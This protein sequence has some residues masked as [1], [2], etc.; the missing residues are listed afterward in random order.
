MKSLFSLSDSQ[1]IRGLLVA[2][3][4]LPAWTAPAAQVKLDSLLVG[5]LSYTN[6]TVL[7][8]TTTHIFFTY[9][10]GS[11][12][13]KL[14]DLEPNLQARFHY[15]PTAAAEAE[16]Q[17]AADEAHYRESIAANIAANIAAQARQAALAAR[18]TAATSAESLADPVS[19][20]SLI[21]KPAPSIE[22]GKWLGE[23]P[24]L[25]GKLVLVVF[26]A[27]WSIPCRKYIPVLDG[28]QKKF[29]GKLAVVGVTSESEAELVDMTEPK[30]GFASLLDSDAKFSASVGVTSIPCIMLV[31]PKGVVRYQGHPA[32][33]TE[34]Q[35]EAILA[36]AAE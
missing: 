11:A 10:G 28:L 20:K 21:G 18:R 8:Y 36:K 12:S 4:L 23:K 9:P 26:W 1:Q 15:D 19:D 14:R 7:S 34:K 24:A 31:D 2:I 6:V 30:A 35:V 3:W 27:P 13:V 32:A 25:E 29:A 22:G 17:Q 5:G 33:I 16:K